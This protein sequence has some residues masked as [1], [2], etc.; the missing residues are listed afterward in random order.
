M[1]LT[2]YIKNSSWNDTIAWVRLAGSV[3][4]MKREGVRRENGHLPPSPE[5]RKLI[6]Y[7]VWRC[8]G[9]NRGEWRKG[10][11]QRHGSHWKPSLWSRFTNREGALELLKTAICERCRKSSLN[12]PST[13]PP[14]H[15]MHIIKLTEE[16]GELS[17]SAYSL[18]ST[19]LSFISHTHSYTH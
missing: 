16:A 9:E 6:R 11:D 1:S 12:P 18:L 4:T 2:K 17:G 3:L 19:V 13:V 7:D 14:G 10:E 8:I 15:I 5:S